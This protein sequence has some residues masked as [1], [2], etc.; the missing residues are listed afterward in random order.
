MPNPNY[1]NGKIYSIRSHRTDK[2]YIGST[3]DTLSRRMSAHR[4]QYKRYKNNKHHFM[5]SFYIFEFGDAYIE[6]LDN[7]SCNSKEEL[8]KTEGELIRNNICVNKCIPDRTQKEWRVDN[9]E[10]LK[11]YYQDN[12]EK[13]KKSN[14]DNK[15]KI[16]IRKEEYY[17]NNK[18]RRK[19]YYN[20]NK[21]KFKE[22]NKCECGIEIQ[23][24][25]IYKHE[26]SKKHK[27]K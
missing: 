27:E 3:I 6:L 8:L 20:N 21:E 4:S 25:S 22:M 12:K 9:K 24:Q 23:K 1:Q 13:I 10:K 26:K 16:S 18:E 5:T 17:N 2:I 15:E 7:C 19:E 14:E 11:E